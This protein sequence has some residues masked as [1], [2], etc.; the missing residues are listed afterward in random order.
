VELP[1]RY[2]FNY[3]HSLR[4]YCG[5]SDVAESVLARVSLAFTNDCFEVQRVSYREVC[6]HT[7]YLTGRGVCTRTPLPV[8][9]TRICTAYLTGRAVCI[10][11]PLPVRYTR[12]LYGVTDRE[13]GGTVGVDLP[14][15]TRS[16]G[17]LR[18]TVVYF[19]GILRWYT[20]VGVGMGMGSTHCT[21]TNP[22][23]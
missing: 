2:L 16:R 23:L 13:C 4:H 17:G 8:R 11:T 22:S 5:R 18:R 3:L 7:T 1:H 12:Y 15:L 20:S 19:R 14:R 10:Q 21:H 6:V 9:Y